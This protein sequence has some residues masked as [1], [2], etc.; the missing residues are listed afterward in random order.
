MAEELAKWPD[1]PDR[2]PADNTNFPR[3]GKVTPYISVLDDK[4]INRE[5]YQMPTI[6]HKGRIYQTDEKGFLINFGDWAEGWAD[7]VGKLEGINELNEEHW[8]IINTSRE[9]Y[10]KNSLEPMAMIL[11]CSA[12]ISLKRIFELFPLGLVEG[13]YKMAGFQNSNPKPRLRS[14]S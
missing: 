9:Y 6:E 5:E 10:S 4:D 12:K 13:V 3:E 7:Y 1:Y 14:S 8:T 2:H 11:S